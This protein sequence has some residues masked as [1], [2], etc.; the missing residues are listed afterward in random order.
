LYK[1]GFRGSIFATEATCSLCDIM[2]RDSAHIQM[3]EAEWRNRKSKRSGGEPYEP[4][5][6]MD[7]A[8]G[9]ISKLRP[10]R[11]GEEIQ[12][13]DSVTVRFTDVGH[14]LG[15]ACIEVWICEG[16]LTR[17]LVFSGDVGNTNQPII[18]DPGTVEDAEYVVVES[19]YGDRLHEAGGR[20]IDYLTD[21]IQRTLDRGGN[22]II[23]SFA[24]GRT[25]EMLFFI[26][27]I[28]NKGMV[29]GH[30]DFPVYVDSPLAIEATGIFLQCNPDC[31]DNETR[32][33][34]TQGINPLMFPNLHTSV[35]RDESKAINFDMEP[36][37][38]IAASGMCE[39]GRIRHH[40]KH[41]LWREDSMILFVGYQAGG[42]LGRSIL[43]GAKSVTL[44]GEKVAVKAEVAM[45]AGKSGHADKNGL[46]KWLSGFRE[47]PKLVFVNHGEDAVTESFAQTLEAEL[48]HKAF[49]PYS[50]TV[51]DLRAEKFLEVPEGIPIEKETSGAERST[52]V[53]RRLSSAAER[54]GTFIH[55][56][57][58]LSNKELARYADQLDALLS[59]WDQ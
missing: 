28:K 40:L 38:I 3:F 16:D 52:A 6:T 21:C 8:E 35:S 39:A 55:K 32:E 36:K 1:N 13:S 34:L 51:F 29:K 9:T 43:E 37:V 31:F 20:N 7:D 47:K 45:L 19:T 2:L 23:P 33:L 50:G 12:V 46:I 17:K 15:S 42:T 54:L 11:Y 44:F 41:N 53:Y 59:K 5:Y 24:V 49:A 10:C 30:N 14:L 56:S 4:V 22:L 25:Q 18:K 58:G 57:K 48:G 27:E 26:R